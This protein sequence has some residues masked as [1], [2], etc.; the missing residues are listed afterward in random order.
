MEDPA[1][2]RFHEPDRAASGCDL[3]NHFQ[4]VSRFIF[5][6]AGPASLPAGFVLLV[7]RVSNFELNFGLS[8]AVAISHVLVQYLFGYVVGWICRRTALFF[9]GSTFYHHCGCFRGA[10]QW[11]E[12]VWFR[13]VCVFFCI[14]S[15]VVTWGIA[16]AGQAFPSDQIRNPFMEY[17][18]PNW[19]TGNIARNFGTI[20]GLKGIFSLIPL[21]VMSYCC[22]PVWSGCWCRKQIQTRIIHY[23]PTLIRSMHDNIIDKSTNQSQRPSTGSAREMVFRGKVVRLDCHRHVLLVT[24]IPYVYAYL[25]TPADKSFMGIMLDVPDHA[26]YFSLDARANHPE[27]GIAIR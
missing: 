20:L 18:L 9:S 13:V 17:A 24:S 14:W 7:D 4:P 12:P 6:R 2:D 25:S 21:S 3:G 1:P 15:G 22:D 23:L 5:P 16:L 11:A 27:P 26:Q 8:A 19:Q 10:S